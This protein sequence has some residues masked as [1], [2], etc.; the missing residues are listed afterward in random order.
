MSIIVKRG[1]HKEKFDEKKTYGSVYAAC[2]SA[3]YGERRCE[4]TAEEITKKIKHFLKN[5]KEVKSRDIRAKVMDELKKKNK[6][7][8]FFYKEHL[9]NLKKL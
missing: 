7:L 6:E 5:K 9:P 8:A 2:A 4:R 1:R 3:H